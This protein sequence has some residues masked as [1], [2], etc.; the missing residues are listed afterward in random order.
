MGTAE[1]LILINKALMTR[2]YLP[3]DFDK[4]TF[5]DVEKWL[6][7]QYPDQ[8]IRAFGFLELDQALIRLRRLE[9]VYIDPARQWVPL[10]PEM[11]VGEAKKLTKEI[12][13]DL[14]PYE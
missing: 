4:K 11:T 7:E 10:G 5:V 6:M 2:D 13:W 12:F 3:S 8:I 14:T 9:F 1:Y